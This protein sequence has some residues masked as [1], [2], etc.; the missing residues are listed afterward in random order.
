L[1]SEKI[2]PASGKYRHYQSLPRCPRRSNQCSK[3]AAHPKQ[4][5]SVAASFPYVFGARLGVRGNGGFFGLNY[6]QFT[7]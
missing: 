1:P 7:P 3:K 6:R 2:S 5:K 4:D